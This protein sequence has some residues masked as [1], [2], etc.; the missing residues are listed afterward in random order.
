[1]ELTLHSVSDRVLILTLALLAS[2]FFGGPL[3]VHRFLL[4]DR[5]GKWTEGFFAA[6][7]RKLNRT[8]RSPGTRR[9]RGAIFIVLVV[10]LCI[11]AG[12]TIGRIAESTQWSLAIEVLILA[13][14]LPVRTSLDRVREIRRTLHDKQETKARKLAETLARRDK[15]TL[16]DKHAITRSAIEYLALQYSRRLIAPSLWYLLLGLPAAFVVVA[17]GLMDAMFGSRAKAYGPYGAVAARLD[18]I[19]Q[20]VPARIASFMFAVAALFSPACS[21][22]R[23]LRG[24]VAGSVQTVSPNSGAVL[25]AVAGALGLSLA[26]PRIFLGWSVKDAWIDYG[27]AKAEVVHLARMQYLYINAVI[28]LL[29]LAAVMNIRQFDVA[30]PL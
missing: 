6:L 18:D 14:L 21:P 19:A 4:L 30:L 15:E 24:A 22:F 23:A 28:L 12:S 25:G 5:P 26:G 11:A 3:S 9:L 16:T 27:T 13:Y 10:V 29:L 8:N 1:M 7:G 17:L 2:A 20:L